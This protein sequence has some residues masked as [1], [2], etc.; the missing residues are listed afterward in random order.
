MGYG[1]YEVTRKDGTTILAGYLQEGPCE[2]Q[3]CTA[4]VSR[5]L[6]ALCGE[7]PGGGEY[8]CGGYFCPDHISYDNRCEK[9]ADKEQEPD[10][11]STTPEVVQG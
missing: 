8:G 5:G 3:I 2:E 9:C 4:T 7:T 1:S 6:D 10:S 11:E